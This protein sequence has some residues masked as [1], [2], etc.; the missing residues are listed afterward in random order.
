MD[1]G[2]II[3]K[4]IV[5]VMRTLHHAIGCSFE[6]TISY[7]INMN[8]ICLNCKQYIFCTKNLLIKKKN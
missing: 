5:C 4:K 7:H 3:M 2:A 1:T 8:K 6:L